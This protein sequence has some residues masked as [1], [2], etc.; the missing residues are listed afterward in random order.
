MTTQ[1][2]APHS[3]IKAYLLV[4]IGL[5]VLTGMT[6]ALSY[7]GLPHGTAILL[8]GLIALTKCTLIAA[9]FMHLRFEK[10][11]IYAILAV[12]LFLVGTLLFSIIPDIGMR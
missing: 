4:F 3:S 9:F 7:M 11:G 1:E 10:K 8:A 5:A 2:S 12:A 6:V